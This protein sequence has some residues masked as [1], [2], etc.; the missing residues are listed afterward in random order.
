[1]AKEVAKKRVASADKSRRI[2]AAARNRFTIQY[3]IEDDGRWIAEIPEIPGVLCYG[4]GP[5]DSGVSALSV[6]LGVLGIGQIAEH[7]RRKAT[8]APAQ[9]KAKKEQR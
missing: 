2:L 9:R 3:D 1:M 7:I 5:F 8:Q 4:G 6:A